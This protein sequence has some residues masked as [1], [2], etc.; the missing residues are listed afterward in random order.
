MQH[1]ETNLATIAGLAEDREDENWEFRSFLKGRDSSIIDEHVHRLNKEI[2]A[3]IDCTACGNCCKTFI[4]SVEPEELEPLATHLGQPV[5][6]VK[7]KYIEQSSEGNFIINTIP[8]H[9][10]SNNKCSIYDHRFST[11]R[12]FPHLDKDDFTQRLISV[13]KN[14]E[15]CPIVFNVFEALKLEMNFR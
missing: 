9:F 12:K 4:I 11:C 10:L 3:Q 5:H 15:I 7:E 1:L 2:A 13:I 6:E 8:C 14:Y